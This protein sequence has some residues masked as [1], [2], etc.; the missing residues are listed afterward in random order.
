MLSEASGP[1]PKGWHDDPIEAVEQDRFNRAPVA[2]RIA[3]LIHR[4]HSVDSSIVYGLE[5]PW[6]C[7]K[8]SVIALITTFLNRCQESKGEWRIVSFTPWATTGI[9]GMLSEFFA[10]LS[11]A[12]PD[13]SKKKGE[14]LLKL[15]ADYSWVV[16]SAAPFVPVI[17]GAVGS[18]AEIVEEKLQKQKP[19]KMLFEELSSGLRELN[20]PVLVIVD[21]IDRLQVDELLVL[22]KVVR[23]LGR[24][25]GVDFLLAYDEQTLVDILRSS[26]RE[27]L[28]QAQA[29]AFMEKIVQYPLTLPP[30]LIGQI[31]NL[32]SDGL[33]EVLLLD[34]TGKGFESHRIS[35]IILETMPSQLGTPR[36]IARFFA[37]LHEEFNIHSPGEVDN[38]DLVLA[39]LLR[40]QFPSVF[41][42]LQYWKTKLTAT[43]D[44]PFET[45]ANPSSEKEV[46]WS[47][48]VQTLECERD[49]KDALTL[50]EAI[51]P[52][53]KGL[54]GRPF[55]SPRFANPNYFDRYLAQSMPE[56][57]IPDGEIRCALG[58]AVENNPGDLK[59]LLKESDEARL[60]LILSKIN[61]HY[62]NVIERSYHDGPRGP[63]KP[64]LLEMAMEWLESIPYAPWVVQAPYL[65]LLRWASALLHLLLEEDPDVNLDHELGAC[66]LPDRRLEVISLAAERVEG[67]GAKTISALKDTL[68]REYRRLVP[69]ILANLRERDG[70]CPDIRMA[71][72]LDQVLASPERDKLIECVRKGLKNNE[73][74]PQDVA[75]RL[76]GLSYGSKGFGAV[77]FDGNLFT[78]LTG[79]SARSID[80]TPHYPLSGNDWVYRRE[81]AASFIEESGASAVEQEE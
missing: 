41:S 64:I 9:D 29:H 63:L 72:L 70:A 77:S 48:L 1:Q 61:A 68:S 78:Q 60:N 51:F 74:T 11:S 27:G 79:V 30:L 31:V 44:S 34:E 26:G 57:D 47:P 16:R 58:K 32:I 19:W 38:T 13:A 12:V 18:A 59:K 42:Q 39:V 53:A 52:A 45:L 33:N 65:A 81:F 17:G 54:A 35:N 40:I 22:L 46:D 23:L 21:D 69:E 50:L 10:A 28:S 66:K 3:K 14:K 55:K 6:G 36:S 76:V 75:A 80:Y 24:F 37:Q 2:E 20:S 67:L 62:P 7:G 5:G 71:F 4:N 73:F 25:P 56:G 8:S 15:L 43:D 49:R